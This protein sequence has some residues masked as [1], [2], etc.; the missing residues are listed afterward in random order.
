MTV[1]CSPVNRFNLTFIFAQSAGAVEYPD[2][3]STGRE[4]FSDECLRYD[5]KQSDGDVSVMLDLWGMRSTFS[6][7]SLLG[8]QW[9]VVV[10]PDRVLLIGQISV[11]MQN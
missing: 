6:F 11:L 8:S 7:P 9:P 1:F 3:I 4:Y 2:C 5:N 10:T